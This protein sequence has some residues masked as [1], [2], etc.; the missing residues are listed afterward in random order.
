M[1]LAFELIYHVCRFNH[2]LC[3]AEQRM[4]DASVKI[5]EWARQHSDKRFPKTWKLTKARLSLK[6]GK[7][8]HLTGKAWQAGVILEYLASLFE[9]NDVPQIANEVKCTV[10]AC[11]NLIGLLHSARAQGLFLQPE[12]IRQGQVVGNYFLRTFVSLNR[13]YI[14]VCPFVLF[15]CRPKLHLVAHMVS[16]LYN[17]RNPVVDCLWMDENWIG[18]IMYLAKKTH[19]RR[20]HASTLF[21]YCAGLLNLFRSLF[22]WLPFFGRTQSSLARSHDAFGL[23]LSYSLRRGLSFPFVGTSVYM[24]S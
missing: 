19:R 21:R 16:A 13:Q 10:W 2:V 22:F 5:K 1:C 17:E 9:T 8:V 12:E 11:N 18:Q 20:T 14:R 23:G 3:Q 24:V 15:H 6:T 4:H 7:P